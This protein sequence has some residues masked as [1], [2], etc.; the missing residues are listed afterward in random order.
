MK[1]TL[2]ETS[3]SKNI[4]LS[5]LICAIIYGFLCTGRLHL[6]ITSTKELLHY[7]PVDNNLHKHHRD[8]LKSHRTKNYTQ[9]E[10]KREINL[11]KV[12]F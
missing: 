8:N 2:L 3:R 10:T 9:D 7:F 6:D 4:N 11:Y 5:T 12:I 1:F